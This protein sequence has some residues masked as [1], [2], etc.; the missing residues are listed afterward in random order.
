MA[1]LWCE[2]DRCN[3]GKAVPQTT[4]YWHW[5]R[6]HAPRHLTSRAQAQRNLSSNLA[7]D[8]NQSEEESENPPDSIGRLMGSEIVSE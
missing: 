7:S 2:C 1:R 4:W 3:G 8:I 5:I 6:L